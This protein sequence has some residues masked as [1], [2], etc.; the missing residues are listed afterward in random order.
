MNSSANTNN[1]TGNPDKKDRS[2]LDFNDYIGVSEATKKFKQLA[3][4]A[5][6][7]KRK[8]TIL[9]IGEKGTGK[10]LIAR[11]IHNNSKS[12]TDKSIFLTCDCSFL[13]PNKL[14]DDLFGHV[15]GA[16]TSGEFVRDGYLKK[17]NNGT[18]FI[19]EIGSAVID[20]QK[21][22]REVIE[23][24][25]FLPL[26]SDEEQYTGARIILA[27]NED[28][29]SM[30]DKGQFLPDLYDRMKRCIIRVPA[31]RERKE[32]IPLLAAF[33]AN[34]FAKDCSLDC[35]FE[36]HDS[37]INKLMEH[38]FPGNVRE[39]DYTLDTAFRLLDETN[40]AI[41][42]A[43]DIKFDIQDSNRSTALSF[44]SL[45]SLEE[46]LKNY[47]K[48]ILDNNRHLW[49]NCDTKDIPALFDF[50]LLAYASRKFVYDYVGQNK[51]VAAKLMN[52]NRDK[53]RKL[54]K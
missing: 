47:A 16:F 19:N 15:K 33:F 45:T 9:I 30:C 11:I 36:L 35:T 52:I 23:Y 39:L 44:N 7:D 49:E 27:T 29:K 43:D 48:L 24:R 46:C 34:K 18:V 25:R 28:L 8:T 12:V 17:A 6:N 37:A 22:L 40:R 5:A 42:K 38:D 4:Y 14:A 2:L 50:D 54:K 13:E 31:L 1:A 20:V 32:D 51:A 26:G 41:L 3:L 21:Q 53:L 10:N